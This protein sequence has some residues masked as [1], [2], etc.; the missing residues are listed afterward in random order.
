MYYLLAIH[1]QSRKRDRETI[2]EQQ[3]LLRAL[4]RLTCTH[5]AVGLCVLYMVLVAFQLSVLLF[6]AYLTPRS[7]LQHDPQLQAD[8]KPDT[9]FD[10]KVYVS[11][12]RAIPDSADSRSPLFILKDHLLNESAHLTV[13]VSLPSRNIQRPLFAIVVLRFPSGDGN[14]DQEE[15]VAWSLI[16]AQLPLRGKPSVEDA[17]SEDGA[18]VGRNAKAGSKLYPHV[19]ANTTVHLVNDQTEWS[20]STCPPDIKNAL[21][22][23]IRKSGSSVLYSPIVWVAEDAWALTSQFTLINDTATPITMH[24]EYSPSS[25]GWWRLSAHVRICTLFATGECN[26]VHIACLVCCADAGVLQTHGAVWLGV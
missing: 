15:M 26:V 18:P 14:A 2:P 21:S 1:Y 24:L 5:V 20:A 4:M 10:L 23:K 12:K 13:N 8:F 9:R 16:T 17:M 3:Q 19:R 7:H 11:D 25:L 6:P 22:R